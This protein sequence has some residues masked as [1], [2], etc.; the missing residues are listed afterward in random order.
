MGPELSDFL[1]TRRARLTPAEVG[2]PERGPRRVTGLRREEVAQL[3]G[4]STDYYVRLE[5]GRPVHVSDQ[6]LNAIARALRFSAAETAHLYALARPP[7]GD[8]VKPRLPVRRSLQIMLDAMDAPALIC[9]Y[10]TRLLATNTLGRAVFGAEDADHER[11]W[12]FFLDPGSREFFPDWDADALTMVSELRV[13]AGRR[14]D[15]RRLATLIGELSIRSPEF[16]ELWA[17]HPVRDKTN[18]TKVINH[19]LVG[20]LELNY[21]RMILADDN[22]A[23]LYVYTPEPGSE[24]VQR[25]ALLASWHTAPPTSETASGEAPASDEPRSTA[26]TDPLG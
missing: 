6:V 21:D 22:D 24:S 26:A 2:L 9:D 16:R 11:A 8:D 15:D 20:R 7:R 10:T 18:G 17:R 5:Q 19:P 12:Y 25:L 23:A 13:Q 1:Q 3:A 4:V 14:P